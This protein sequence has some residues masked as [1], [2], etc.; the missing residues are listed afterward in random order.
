MFSRILSRKM[1]FHKVHRINLHKPMIKYETVSSL[2]S[3][4]F[5]TSI[6]KSSTTSFTS[7]DLLSPKLLID[8]QRLASTFS[9]SKMVSQIGTNSKNILIGVD[10]NELRRAPTSA[11]WITT[12]GGA[13]FMTVPVLELIFGYSSFLTTVEMGIGVTFLSMLGSMKWGHC[14]E[15]KDN[16]GPT[17]HNLTWSMLPPGVAVLS[18]MLPEGIGFLV[19]T[20][21]ISHALYMDIT[22]YTYPQWANALGCYISTIAIISL[23]LTAMGRAIFG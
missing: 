6:Q 22:H 7:R 13:C 1:S 21:G 10:F 17:W 20:G 11:F 5:K 19:L 14:L 4:R 8:H 16:N 3:D 12:A 23:I 18:F 9:I 15:R 2:L